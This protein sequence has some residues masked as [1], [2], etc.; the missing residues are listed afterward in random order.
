[1]LSTIDVSCGIAS[2]TASCTTTLVT[3]DYDI[4]GTSTASS[5]VTSSGSAVVTDIS[6]YTM[7]VTVTAGLDKLTSNTTA[8]ATANASSTRPGGAKGTEAHTQLHTQLSDQLAQMAVQLKR[9][10]LHFASSLEADKA[11]FPG[12]YQTAVVQGG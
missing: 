5:T 10:A 12:C 2:N 9:N 7:P 11:A 6:S 4:Q 8:T 3:V 1:M